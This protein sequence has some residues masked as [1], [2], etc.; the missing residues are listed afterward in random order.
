MTAQPWLRMPDRPT[1][2]TVLGWY[3]IIDLLFV[4]IYGGINWITH[5]RTDLLGLYLRTELAVPLV[6][7]A[8]WIYFSLFI[9]FLLPI[10]VL[11]GERVREEARAAIVGLIIAAAIWLL[12]PARLGFERV[13]PLGYEDVYGL[14]FALDQ[15]HNLVPSLH[16][17]FSTLVVLA[18]V[19]TAPRPQRLVLWCWLGSISLST[20]LTHQHH[21]LDLATGVLLAF[22]CRT[23]ALRWPVRIVSSYPW[24]IAMEKKG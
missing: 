12:L 4:T 7:E 21:L 24:F 17:V 13:L 19:E 20:L 11:P 6:P 8:I 22:F 10:F 15:P 3:L 23:V 16:V 5:Q 18:C 14:V 1:L 9:L 2:K